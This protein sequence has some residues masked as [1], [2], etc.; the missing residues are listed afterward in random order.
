MYRRH[1]SRLS[2]PM[3]RLRQHYRFDMMLPRLLSW[4][5]SFFFRNRRRLRQGRLQLFLDRLC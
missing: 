1:L 5:D 4:R 2:V 3:L